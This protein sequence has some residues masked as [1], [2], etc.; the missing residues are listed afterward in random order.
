VSFNSSPQDQDIRE[1]VREATNIVDLI[2][3]YL[4]LRRQGRG[5][6][7]LCPWHNDRRPSLQVNPVQGTW[8][9][10]VCN[11]GGDAFSFVMKREAVGFR[12]A[13]QLL[14]DRAGIT[15]PTRRRPQAPAGSP[16]DKRTL[17]RAAAWAQEQFHQC[18]CQSP[19]AADARDYLRDRRISQDSVEKFQ[20]GYSPDRWSW[21]LD[22]ARDAEFSPAVLEAAGLAIPRER[23]AGHYD[24][25]RGRLLFPIRDLQ[26]RPIAFGGR[27]LPGDSDGKSAK[28]INS[29]ETLL[30]SKSDNLYGLDVA[31]D[32]V[33][34]ERQI[35]VV[36]GYTDT[37][38]AHQSGVTNVAAVLGTA[39]GAK[40]IE[41]LRRFA[42]TVF[43]VLDGDEAGRRRSNEIL[44]FFLAA[45]LDMRLLTLPSG[46][47]PA[48]YL[49][50]NGAEAFNALL[51]GA[52]DALEY[53]FRVATEGVDL[54]NDTH[55]ANQALEEI[56]ATLAEVP[57]F[58]VGDRSASKI[59]EGQVL[60]RLSRAFGMQPEQL[61]SRL[62][63]L[64]RKQQ[65]RKA[66]KRGPEEP[67]SAN[68][69][70]VRG[71]S[72]R[73]GELLEVLVLHP[74]LVAEA[75]SQIEE[76][77]LESPVARKLFHTIHTIHEASRTADFGNVLTALDDPQL[78][79]VWVE[80]DDRA[81]R[82]AEDA[83]LTASQRLQG[84]IEYF[85]YAPIRKDR[86]QTQA[87][88]EEKRLKDDEALAALQ[89]LIFQE[90]NRRGISGPKDG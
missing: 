88:L 20:L 11:V 52:V 75:T 79:Y 24:R 27:I 31:R 23:S 48:D 87:A 81:Q 35:V 8:K 77:Q 64:R 63:E 83:Q 30:F 29:P 57:A 22:R 16:Q 89:Q 86:Q 37:I 54:N 80:L 41:V 85:H 58:Q 43:L 34:R 36:E 66:P 25:F 10:W 51:D 39:L 78:K 74:E 7:A 71:L 28:Y 65:T 45:R 15:L 2:G 13:L 38:I 72:G 1:Q 14:A 84:L 19:E 32:A 90:R 17:Y 53:K 82:K 62:N 68:A 55:R 44:R 12:E 33:A 67:R 50:D 40:H 4:Q 6:V 76:G 9:C 69:D 47:D 61:R 21:L 60:V 70:Q 3:S 56:L 26:G 49:L 18:L 73:E 5:Y 59:R 42:D 46:L